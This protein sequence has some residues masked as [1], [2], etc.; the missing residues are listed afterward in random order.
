MIS[1]LAGFE[2]RHPTATGPYGTFKRAQVTLAKDYVRKLAPLGIR[3]NTV[4][5]GTIETPNIIWA[6]GTVSETAYQ[7]AKRAYPDVIQGFVDEVP[8]KRAGSPQDVANS[9]LFLSSRLASYINGTVVVV[10]GGLSIGF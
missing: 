3:I 1:S 5:P 6:D 8:L 4:V 2:R 7:R 10:D 9:V